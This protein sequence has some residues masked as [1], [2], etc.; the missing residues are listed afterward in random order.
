LFFSKFS[1][2]VLAPFYLFLQVNWD[3]ALANIEVTFGGP[4][5]PR[6]PRGMK[7][8]KAVAFD[9]PIFGNWMRLVI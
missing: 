4:Q 1:I 3:T 6:R 2:H 5:A 8:S 7:P 9:S